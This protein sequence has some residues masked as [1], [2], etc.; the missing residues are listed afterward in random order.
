M[1]YIAELRMAVWK[2]T[3]IG[4]TIVTDRPYCDK[5]V[6]NIKAQ[7]GQNVNWDTIAS[8]L[9]GRRKTLTITLNKLSEY[10]LEDD[11]ATY[12]DFKIFCDKTKRENH[13]PGFTNSEV[14][15]NGSETGNL[16]I[17][18][19]LSQEKVDFTIT[20]DRDINNFTDDDKLKFAIAI[21]NLLNINPKGV[22][23][24]KI[25]KGSVKI[26]FELTQEQADRLE[27]TLGRGALSEWN[28]L[29]FGAKE[30][31]SIE[32]KKEEAEVNKKPWVILTVISLL[33]VGLIYFV[34]P[35]TNPPSPSIRTSERSLHSF[36]SWSLDSFLV[37]G[38]Q[39]KDLDTLLVS[40]YRDSLFF[41]VGTEIGDYY[42]KFGETGWDEIIKNL[43]YR[44]I[45]CGECCRITLKISNFHP[46]ERDQQAGFLLFY[47]DTVDTRL[48]TRFTYAYSGRNLDSTTILHAQYYDYFSPDYA[49]EGPNRLNRTVLP[50]KYD[51]SMKTDSIWLSVT[52]RDSVYKFSYWRNEMPGPQSIGQGH[53]LK[54]G[55]PK[56]VGIGAWQGHANRNK[57][58]PF[59][60]DTIPVSFNSLRIEPCDER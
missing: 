56:V 34:L 45:D 50:R 58:N 15:S 44:K 3:N 57:I 55:A 16:N 29:N 11:K 8:F 31:P 10:V 40:K 2:K 54:T 1:D 14:T 27:E 23:I 28:I 21:A 5:I 38:W 20:I 22:K 33:V 13:S 51:E 48:Y 60:A 46:Y 12:I 37:N 43:V 59:R 42:V 9:S 24:K 4:E 49:M 35:D 36:R 26:T 53:K 7:T 18:N 6:D 41:T 47:S 30:L 25:E 19:E 39:V 17:I 52:I 32:E